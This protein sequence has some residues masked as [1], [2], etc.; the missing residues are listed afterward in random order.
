[1]LRNKRSFYVCTIGGFISLF[2]ANFIFADQYHYNNMLI[3]NRAAGLAG[4]YVAVAD[5][6]SGLYYN[7]SG[8]VYAASGNITANM[9]AYSYTQTTYADALESASGKKVDW[10]RTSSGLIPNF[11]GITQPLGPGTIGFS[12]A[13]TDSILEDQTQAFS[14]T[15][16]AGITHRINFNNQDTTNNIGPSYAISINDNLSVGLTLYG[17]IRNQK[18]ILNQIIDVSKVGE[19]DIPLEDRAFLIDNRYLTL[20]EYG[21]KPILGVTY[22][23]FNKLS[24]GFT[25]SQVFLLSSEV[26]IQ[27]SIA[28][29]NCVV[30]GVVERCTGDDPTVFDLI[31]SSDSSQRE[32]PWQVSMGAAYFHSNRLMLTGTAWV[33]K[34]IN[35]TDRPLINVAGGLEYYIAGKIAVRMGAYTNFANTPE[36]K[37]ENG[38]NAKEHLNIVGGTMSITN[39]TRSSAISIGFSG[40][41]GKGEAQ[42]GPDT[43]SIQNVKYIGMSLFLSAS[44]SF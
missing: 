17:Y 3:G 15:P 43:A 16:L 28:R 5:D 8:V 37:L 12:Y 6:P 21:V 20:S 40:S 25:A 11:F 42:V 18:R 32:F 1:M 24:F 29:N 38:T 22:T 13:V 36:I 35:N 26:K 31:Q 33:Y 19:T 27:D 4:A 44:N 30:D 41:Y 10:V 14:D 39:F 7:P 34:A 23:P 9:N 2:H